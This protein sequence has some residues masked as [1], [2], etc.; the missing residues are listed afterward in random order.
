[1]RPRRQR[2]GEAEAAGVEAD[3]P[4]EPG[5]ALGVAVPVGL[6]HRLVDGDHEP[7]VELQHDRR[8]RDRLCVPRS[9]SPRAGRRAARSGSA[10]GSS[11]MQSAVPAPNP[12]AAEKTKR[13]ATRPPPSPR[14]GPKGSARPAQ[15]PARVLPGRLTTLEGDRPLLDGAHVPR[16]PLEQAAAPGRQVRAHER[17]AEGQAVVVDQVEVAQR[18]SSTVPRS[19]RP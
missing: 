6:V 1:M 19:D 12:P 11:Q 10:A 3:E 17:C 18:A 5:D 8:R 9:G 2:V 15:Q 16:G 7:A 14:R 4:A 13:R